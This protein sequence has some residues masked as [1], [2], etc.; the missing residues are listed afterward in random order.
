MTGYFG[1]YDGEKVTLPELLSWEMKHTD[2]NGADC[3]TLCFRFSAGWEPIL[4]KANRLQLAEQGTPRFYGLVDEY[5]VSMTKDGM[6]VRVYGRGMAGLMMDNQVAQ[7]V[8]YYSRLSDMVKNY[9]TP[10]GIGAPQYDRNPWLLLYGVDYG[11]TAWDAFGGFCNW[12]LEVT[13]R[14]LPDGTL[15]I[16]GR[17][18]QGQELNGVS[19][20]LE[21]ERTGCRYGVYSAV[22][23]K[24]LAGNYERRF[25]NTDFIKRG[26]CAVHRMTVPRRYQC[27]AGL[28][29]PQQVL[30]ASRQG[31]SQIKVRLSAGFWAQPMDEVTV[32]LPKLGLQ[33]RFLVTETCNRGGM[34]GR[35]CTLTMYEI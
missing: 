9:V 24:Y 25:D 14:F 23:A 35:S 2:G 17:H 32:N 19:P 31:E 1:L 3:V 28:K 30:E 26:G 22:R 12:A 11:E 6:L 34:Q 21:V 13:P 20:I 16:S 10:Y 33:G 18:G 5:T 8:Y 7:R 29:S 27:R 4:K 15:D